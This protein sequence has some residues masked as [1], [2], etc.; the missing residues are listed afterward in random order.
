MSL[1]RILCDEARVL[2]G[3]RRTLHRAFDVTMAESGQAALDRLDKGESFDVLVSDM[4]MPN[5]NG[6]TLLA[7]FCVRAPN[8]T[9]V[10]LT[11]QAD[12][13]SAIAAVNKGQIFRFLT[14][15]CSPEE[16]TAA[17]E[18][19]ARQHRLVTAEKVLLEETL[20]GSVRA[21]TEVMSLVSPEVFGLAMRQHARVRAVADRLGLSDAW[22]VEVASMLSSVG[23]AVLPGD[24]ATK[25][26]LGVPLDP[27]EQIMANQ[28]PDVVQRV[29]AHIPRIDNV[30]AL[31]S[32]YEALRASPT[33]DESVPIGARILLAVRDLAMLEAS[34][35]DTA[36]AIVALAGRHAPAIIDALA[37]VC[38][39]RAPGVRAL[40]LD[41]LRSGMV[42]AADIQ[43][44]SGTLLVAH[45][46]AVTAQLIQRIRNFHQRV[47]VAEPILCEV[48]VAADAEGRP[49]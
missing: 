6:A 20:L 7:E 44:R 9:R 15:P 21:L 11:G 49:H 36:R 47:G 19:A 35:G 18:A 1:S 3:I 4:R 25:L 32:K 33:P 40:T 27:A 37:A 41:D 10:L 30:R 31:L 34:E 12:I 26:Q 45:G 46:Q 22:H 14:K 24:V 42:L 16:L 23:Y 28:V 38:E 13:Q 17:L 39:A 2:D 43:T 48:R 5:M 29:L 8:T